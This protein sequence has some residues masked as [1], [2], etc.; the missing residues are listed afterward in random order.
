MGK[1]LEKMVRKEEKMKI[2]KYVVNKVENEY[3]KKEKL[4]KKKVFGENG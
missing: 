4:M 2:K 1:K 3:G